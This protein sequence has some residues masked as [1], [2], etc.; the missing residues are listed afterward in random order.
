[1]LPSLE[2]LM[3]I[4]PARAIGVL[5]TVT[6][7]LIAVAT[8]ALLG[9]LRKRELEHARLDT[10]SLAHVLREQLRQSFDNADLVI[11]GVQERMQTVYGSTLPLDSPSVQLL[12]S[13]RVSGVRELGNL[14]LVDAKGNVVNAARD[15]ARLHVSQAGRDY[16]KALSA[17]KADG[18]FIERPVR[19]AASD[20]GWAFDLAQPFTDTSGQ[21]RGAVVATMS[22]PHLE[23]FS[24]LVKLDYGRPVALYLADG[25]LVASLPARESMVGERPP[26]LGGVE[27][28]GPGG[29]L[30]MVTH[31][32]GDGAQKTFALG[33]V[34]MLPLLV[35]VASDEDQ[36]LAR[37]R[38]T[39]VPIALGATLVC[40][41]IFIAA[42]VLTHEVRRQAVLAQAL[43]D[44]H[45]RYHKTIDSVMDAIVAV[46]ESQAVILFNPAAESMFGVKA[47]QVL[48]RQLAELVPVRAREAHGHHLEMFMRSAGASRPMAPNIDITGLRA[49]GEEFP[50]ESTISQTQVDGKTQL[51]AVLRD[52][53]Q[54]R[55]AEAELREMNRQ[56]RALSASLQNVREQERKRISA[57]LHDELG[58]QLTG[59]KLDLVWLA[60]RAKEGR[61]ATAEQIDAMRQLLDATISS[62]RR[63]AADLRPLI[64]GDLGFGEAVTWQTA[65][66]AKR[67]GLVITMDLGGAEH[68]RDDARATALFRI[69]QESLTNVARHAGASEVQIRLAAEEDQ[70]VLTVRDDGSGIAPGDPRSNRNGIGLVSMRER[71]TALGGQL[72]VASIAGRGTT[73]EVTLPLHAAALEE[74]AT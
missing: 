10:V 72:R 65:E 69:V 34:G 45:D 6:I 4:R 55:R 43:R 60:G 54:R 22:L 29:A 33:R 3:E 64:L 49:D 38:E 40:V 67:S 51:T 48:G 61:A 21:F 58:Q 74:E 42:M 66:F 2:L 73:I 16:F 53:T 37:W 30:K 28:P 15:E 11:R 14:F 63:I 59:L 9:E 68:V 36:A 13:A 19:N 50:I 41:F 24:S 26:E 32:S 20:G 8:I 56:L 44:A 39:S 31:V 57:E 47:A 12:L 18:L 27:L 7:T 17:G 71:A 46:D 23:Q 52:V 62:V 5:A 35:S 25:T 1:M 70:L